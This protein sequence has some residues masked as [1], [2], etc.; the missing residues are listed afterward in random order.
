MINVVAVRAWA[1]SYGVDVQIVE[2]AFGAPHK[3]DDLGALSA[4]LDGFVV[5]EPVPDGARGDVYVRLCSQQ[6]GAVPHPEAHLLVC[7]A[8][9]VGSVLVQ[10]G[11]QIVFAPLRVLGQNHAAVDIACSVKNNYI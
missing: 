8:P 11:L 7:T 5:R 4:V 10:Q 2:P 6:V 3:V 9:P 1:R